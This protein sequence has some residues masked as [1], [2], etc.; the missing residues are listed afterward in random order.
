MAFNKGCHEEGLFNIGGN[1]ESCSLTFARIPGMKRSNAIFYLKI[2]LSA[3]FLWVKDTAD[4][5]MKVVT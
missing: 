4:N 2:N 3:G 1:I 5:L